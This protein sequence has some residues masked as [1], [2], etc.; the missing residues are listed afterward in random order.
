MN[1]RPVAALALAAAVAAV[2]VRALG[3]GPPETSGAAPASGAVGQAGADRR[4][5]AVNFGDDEARVALE[6]TVEV[7]TDGGGEGHRF[8]GR[9]APA[10]GVVLRQR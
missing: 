4:L 1:R 6:G 3:V 10:A 9:L 2:P 7:S 8:A 5:V